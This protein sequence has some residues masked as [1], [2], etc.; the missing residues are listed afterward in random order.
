MR[1]YTL[2]KKNPSDKLLQL[3]YDILEDCLKDTVWEKDKTLR[4][5]IA[6]MLLKKYADSAN[7]NSRREQ[8]AWVGREIFTY[9]Q[10][11]L[12]PQNKRLKIDL[13]DMP[14]Q[15]EPLF[16]LETFLNVLPVGKKAAL[17]VG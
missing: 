3:T 6:D 16:R 7:I 9:M 14:K 10:L 4:P 17:T 8:A 15:Y 12:D 1:N 13:I 2:W 11:R 5:F